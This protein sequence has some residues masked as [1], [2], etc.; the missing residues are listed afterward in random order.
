MYMLIS[1]FEFEIHLIF[2]CLCGHMLGYAVFYF[3]YTDPIIVPVIHVYL[4]V[5][6]KPI[7]SRAGACKFWYWYSVEDFK[8]CLLLPALLCQAFFD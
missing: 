4:F 2:V 3:H 8:G 5:M 6:V 1:N 7:I